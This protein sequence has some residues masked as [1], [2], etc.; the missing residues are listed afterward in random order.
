MYTNVHSH[1]LTHGCVYQMPE[2][3]HKL[4]NWYEKYHKFRKKRTKIDANKEYKF[5]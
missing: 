5:N 4:L 2:Y 1:T 3:N